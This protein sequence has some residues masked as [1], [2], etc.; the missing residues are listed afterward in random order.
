M[1]VMSEM[2][3][4]RAWEMNGHFGGVKYAKAEYSKKWCTV[5]EKIT[6]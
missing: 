5:D 3:A 1:A 6:S 4:A 2:A